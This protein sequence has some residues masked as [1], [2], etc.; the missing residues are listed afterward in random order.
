MEMAYPSLQVGHL[1]GSSGRQVG[2]LSL[3]AGRAP[4]TVG[5]RAESPKCHFH[6]DVRYRSSYT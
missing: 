1:E 6:G 2:I 4:D 5:R 3:H